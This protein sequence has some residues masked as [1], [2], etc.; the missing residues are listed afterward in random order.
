MIRKQVLK[1]TFINSC[2]I[3]FIGIAIFAFGISILFKG[4]NIKKNTMR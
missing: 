2:V 3:F 1:S 4:I